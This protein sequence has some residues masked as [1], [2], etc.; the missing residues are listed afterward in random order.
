MS[1]DT[2]TEH[3]D[4]MYGEAGGHPDEDTV[5]ELWI[6]AGEGAE[7][8]GPHRERP[9]FA[10]QQEQFEINIPEG[11]EIGR[12]VSITRSPAT[13]DLFLLN[14]GWGSFTPVD[15]AMRLNWI[16]RFDSEGNFLNDFG[17]DDS[18]P[19]VNGIAQFPHSPDHVEVDD[20]GNVCVG[21]FH[22]YDNAVVMF[23]P[24]G[25]F[26]RQYGQRGLRGDNGDTTRWSSPPSVYHDV[27]DR[28]LFMAD[29]YGNNRIISID[30]D[31]G[32]FRR[33]WGAFG[34]D[35]NDLSP[36]ESW[37][38]PVHKIACA[39]DG[40]MY[41]AD[42]SKNR[43]QE[44]E[45]TPDSVDYV[46]EVYVGRATPTGTTWDLAFTPDNKYM[47]VA[48]GVGMKV[49]TVDRDTFDVLGWTSVL[50]SEGDHNIGISM[51]PLHRIAL[52]AEGDL[53]LTG[54]RKGFSRLKYLG[55]S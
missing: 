38:S 36:E 42:R 41:V 49:W 46:R 3:L 39:P 25:E 48:D 21:G 51:L 16:V 18:V 7:Y 9:R 13:G 2:A 55:V 54:R 31:T 53:L 37:G 24:E 32:E 14:Y 35:P 50:E 26:I 15:P 1:E 47:F 43:V 17:G 44:F 11:K 6:K 8:T 12:G 34:Q 29:G 23:S 5:G 10:P 4:P 40:R 28:E 52:T 45:V 30:S 33:M 22:P 20:E 27:K 19:R